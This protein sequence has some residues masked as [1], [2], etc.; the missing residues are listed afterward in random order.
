[1][2]KPGG[3]KGRDGKLVENSTISN[4]W[5]PL[6]SILEDKFQVHKAYEICP[7]SQSKNRQTKH[8]K[9]VKLC[10]A[11]GTVVV[12]TNS[13]L[14]LNRN[15]VLWRAKSF[16]DHSNRLA[17]LSFRKSSTHLKNM[18]QNG[19]LPQIG[20]NIKTYLSCHHLVPNLHSTVNKENRCHRP[21][22]NCARPRPAV[23]LI[24]L[25]RAP[26]SRRSKSS[27]NGWIFQPA[28]FLGPGG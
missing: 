24:P 19:Y 13:N 8:V 15:T 9:M 23:V 20:V 1:M 27:G 28:M 6:S 17:K 2:R 21:Q 26:V 7:S 10:K 22:S 25:P 12:F 14:N 3:K 18:S 4:H 11:G 16:R 5:W